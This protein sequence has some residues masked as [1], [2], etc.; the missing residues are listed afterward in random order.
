V[1]IFRG[2][3]SK[4]FWDDTHEL[5]SRVKPAELEKGVRDKA[6]IKFNITKDGYERQAVCTAQFEEDDLVPMINGLVARLSGQQGTIK[7]IKKIIAN[8][9]TTDAQKLLK[10]G[11][12]IE[13]FG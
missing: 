11:D 1:R 4:P 12:A 7:E 5:V 3:S 6:L 9:T 13:N 10:I 2:P 8:K